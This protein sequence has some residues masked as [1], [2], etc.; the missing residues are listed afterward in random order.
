MPLSGD[1]SG[2]VDIVGDLGPIR[3]IAIDFRKDLLYWTE[4]DGSVARISVSQLD[5]VCY[6]I[7][8]FSIYW[9]NGHFM[10]FT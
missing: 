8:I 4:F 5:G 2:G 7:F 10:S 6:A 1:I 3:S 9:C